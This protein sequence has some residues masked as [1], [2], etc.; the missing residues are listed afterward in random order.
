M[1][2]E[3]KDALILILLGLWL[4]WWAHWLVDTL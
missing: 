4:G 1:T 3:T 2:K